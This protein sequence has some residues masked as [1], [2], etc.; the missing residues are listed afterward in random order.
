M[1]FSFPTDGILFQLDIL[2]YQ[3]NFRDRIMAICS[4]Q[5][6]ENGD[7][8]TEALSFSDCLFFI[9][10]IKLVNAKQGLGFGNSGSFTP[11]TI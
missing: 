11:G 8:L 7:Q 3:E 4:L 2:F 10:S 6:K 9:R 1:G 5:F